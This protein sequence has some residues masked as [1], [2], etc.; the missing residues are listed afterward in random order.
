MTA[1]SACYRKA[2]DIVAREIADE[3][4]LVP[5]RNNVG[6]LNSIYT[7]N[8]TA[9]FAWSLLDGQRTLQTI[10]DQIVAEYDVD[11]EQAESDLLE[12]FDTLQSLQAVVPVE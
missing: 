6:D 8:E 9:A 10:C 2:D 3:V 1:L 12:L 5:I 4:I 7:L 11:A